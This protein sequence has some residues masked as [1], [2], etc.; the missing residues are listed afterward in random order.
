[1]NDIDLDFMQQMQND[2]F[3]LMEHWVEVNTKVGASAMAAV[4]MTN[5][6]KL[7]RTTLSEEEYNKMVD[8]I[9]SERHKVPK[10]DLDPID[11]SKLN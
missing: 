3:S 4:L 1:M 9:S 8:L 11:R 7:Y 6:L 10:W 2:V 5:A